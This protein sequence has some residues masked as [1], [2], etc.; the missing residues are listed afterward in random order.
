[1][2]RGKGRAP[3]WRARG[4]IADQSRTLAERLHHR[5]VCGAVVGGWRQEGVR[6]D[7]SARGRGRQRVAH[8]PPANARSARDAPFMDVDILA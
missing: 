3:Q 5:E 4:R 1:M 7:S 6:R 8:S 2:R